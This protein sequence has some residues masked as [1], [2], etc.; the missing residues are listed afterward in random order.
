MSPGLLT[1][2]ACLC[3]AAWLAGCHTW[4]R[5]SCGAA[6]RSVVLETPAA[7]AA[8]WADAA[9]IVR[10]EVA[11]EGPARSGPGLVIRVGAEGPP[12]LR[13]SCREE[14][15]RISAILPNLAVDAATGP[16]SALSLPTPPASATGREALELLWI[17]AG[18]SPPT[19]SP[20]AR[21]SDADGG[22]VL[23]WGERAWSGG[24]AQPQ[25]TSLPPARAPGPQE[26][27]PSGHL[28][29]PD[30]WVAWL[31]ESGAPVLLD[32]RRDAG[33]VDALEAVPG[34]RADLAYTR[35]GPLFD[36]PVYP[37]DADCL[38]TP[39]TAD[40]LATAQSS[41]LDDGLTLV[42]W[43]CYRPPAVQQRM[44]EILPD[45]RYV[46]PPT[47]SGSAHSRGTAVDVTL[48]RVAT[49]RLMDM[50]TGHDDFG[51]AAHVGAGPAQG[52]SPEQASNRG[53]LAQAMMEAG[54]RGTPAE[55]W[56]YSGPDSD[57]RE[58]LE[59]PL[60]DRVPG[61]AFASSG[62]S[63]SGGGEE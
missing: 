14:I 35:P 18:L 36:E 31:D 57:K 58:P 55:W 27:P 32:P 28:R 11:Q 10:A 37:A 42:L 51:P 17:A 25:P 33:L 41:L 39:A 8:S 54:L 62:G 43:D 53:R 26:A 52:V 30:G 4:D 13:S 38:L 20:P 46:A 15:D 63:P 9:A 7:L 19:T 44:W 24:L 40:G 22:V 6:A 16:D 34:V 45:P 12:R 23:V 49:G 50:P 29:G 56:H 5:G 47:G 59:L 1:R 60:S 61:D 2:A 3:A 21:F 48:A